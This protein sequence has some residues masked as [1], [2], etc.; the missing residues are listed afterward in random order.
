MQSRI[1][2]KRTTLASAIA[3]ALGATTANADELQ[4]LKA[5]VEA[6]QKK[7]VELEQKQRRRNEEGQTPLRTTSSRAVRPKARSS[8]PDRTPPSP[9]AAT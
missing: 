9:L 4:D 7:V 5:Q 3:I 1:R 2:V 6:L 8:C